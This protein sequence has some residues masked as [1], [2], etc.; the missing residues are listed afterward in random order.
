M[1]FPILTISC[2]TIFLLFLS[3]FS[4]GRFGGSKDAEKFH[5]W[6][7]KVSKVIDEGNE[8]IESFKEISDKDSI[9]L[10]ELVILE[11]RLEAV[12][13]QLY[14]QETFS[15]KGK[16]KEQFEKITADL[17]LF[18]DDYMFFQA[19]I[20]TKKEKYERIVNLNRQLDAYQKLITE[21]ESKQQLLARSIPR[22]N[23]TAELSTVE[24]ELSQLK[25]IVPTSIPSD[26]TLP[27]DLQV[28]IER[29]NIKLQE[30][31]KKLEFVENSIAKYRGKIE[32]SVQEEKQKQNLSKVHNWLDSSETRIMKLI[33][34]IKKLKEQATSETTSS[35]DLINSL[36]EIDKIYTDISEI[37]PPEID[38]I[39]EKQTRIGIDFRLKEL[40]RLQDSLH[41]L[42]EQI[43]SNIVYRIAFIRS[44]ILEK[45]FLKNHQLSYKQ[46]NYSLGYK[47]DLLL[48][49]WLQL[50]ESED[51]CLKDFQSKYVMFSKEN[52]TSLKESS[53]KLF[54]SLKALTDFEFK[55]NE[56]SFNQSLKWLL[57][58]DDKW[59]RDSS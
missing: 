16:D 34:K 1:L 44:S 36:K 54:E 17:T 11:S 46:V 5:A 14:A 41:D 55:T 6:A 27:E 29:A 52:I 58:N 7:E 13:P 10:E 30:W 42:K 56:Q 39:G 49:G 20:K 37:K 32:N 45:M 48:L 50:P 59:I 25:T 8:I 28:K 33:E 57:N 40:I 22:L 21:H 24:E 31:N 12:E 47:N 18:Q 9:T 2:L 3:V 51:Y 43:N 53:E 23:T 35:K 15:L 38:L 4:F 19:E 26:L